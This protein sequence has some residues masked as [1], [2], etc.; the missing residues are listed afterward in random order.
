MICTVS[1]ILPIGSSGIGTLANRARSSPEARP[2][3]TFKTLDELVPLV[4]QELATSDWVTVTQEQVDLYAEVTG[5]HAGF[6]MLSL[7]PTLFNATVGI[8]GTGKAINH[9]ID[10]LRF[11]APVPVGSKLRCRVKLLSCEPM[12]G[13]GLQLA[14][15]LKVMR[16]GEKRPVCVAEFVQYRYP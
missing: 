1:G 15:D 2:A 14:F 9:G 6:P 13:A 8:E 11:T 16:E 5:G 3:R 7:L 10:K 12:V 4:G